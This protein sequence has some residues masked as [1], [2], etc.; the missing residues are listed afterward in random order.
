MARTKKP[1]HGA[2]GNPAMGAQTV[3]RAHR[4]PPKETGEV[5]VRFDPAVVRAALAAPPAAGKRGARAARTAGPLPPTLSEPLAWLAHNC[6]LKHVEPLFAAA[7]RGRPHAAAGGGRAGARHAAHEAAVV[8]SVR[9]PPQDFLAGFGLLRLDPKAVNDRML[10]KLADQQGV[11]AADRVPRRWMLAKKAK[12]AQ[13]DPLRNSQWALRAIGWFDQKLPDASDVD[14]AVLDTG[15][16][17]THPDL[18]RRIAH[19]DTGG[20]SRDDLIGHG[21]HVS[22]IVA[23]IADNDIGVTGVAN[24]RLRV[25]KIFGD[26]P[27]SD[28]EI[29]VDGDTYLRALGY[30]AAS[31]ARVVNLSIGGGDANS[32]EQSL[33]DL[34]RE[35][36]KVV[37]AA[38]GNEYEEG[39]PVEYPSAY[40]NVIGVGAVSVSLRRSSFSNTGDHIG[41]V[42]PG[43]HILSTLPMK[44]SAFR[45]PDEVEYAFW[46]GTSMATPCVAGCL[47]LAFA[48]KPKLAAADVAA[49]LRKLV[50]KV[51][52][53]KGKAFT[54]QYGYGLVSIPRILAAV[55]AL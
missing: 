17:A 16:D 2:Y 43:R 42:A 3:E 50:R 51:P 26:T 4:T 7:G 5:V 19:Y 40:R 54:R 38:M 18:A 11:L 48:K 21:T 30:A 31:P 55:K 29:Y 20:H 39:N 10:R 1:A 41:L 9:E 15:V 23:A 33:F 6:G 34:L 52:G 32:V 53:M 45:E 35:R 28:G 12:P 25:W 46:D 8:A 27:E 24:C 49:N 22:G 14:V 36:G 44:R 47:A 13:V 37:V